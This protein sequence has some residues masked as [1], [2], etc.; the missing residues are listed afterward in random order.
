MK[1]LQLLEGV[2]FN[3]RQPRAEPLY[4]DRDS[5]AILFSLKPGQSI[6]EHRAPDSPFFV[7][8]LKGQGMFVG[9]EGKEQCLGPDTL[10][11]FD[12]NEKHAI[13]AVDEELVFV[14]FLG[15]APSNVT[16]K[17]GGRLA[18]PSR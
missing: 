4:V 8:V 3:V 16:K 7:V 11:V 2:K 10:L 1:T 9:G 5:R 12:R 15:G 14:G 13:R 6:K 18:R 17:Q